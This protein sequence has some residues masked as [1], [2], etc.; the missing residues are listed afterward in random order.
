MDSKIMRRNQRTSLSIPDTG[1][2]IEVQEMLNAEACL[3]FGGVQD[4]AV[5]ESTI[6]RNVNRE[7]KDWAETQ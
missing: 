3:G 7:Q 5:Y 2:S 4:L 6:R 1:R